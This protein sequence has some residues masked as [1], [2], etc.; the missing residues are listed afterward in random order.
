MLLNMVDMITLFSIALMLERGESPFPRDLRA[1]ITILQHVAD[2]GH[3]GA[4]EKLDHISDTP[5]PSSF[6][7]ASRKDKLE[8]ISKGEFEDIFIEE[9]DGADMVNE[10]LFIKIY[11]HFRIRFKHASL[12]AIKSNCELYANRKLFSD[13]DIKP[14][15]ATHFLRTFYYQQVRRGLLRSIVESDKPVNPFEDA[16]EAARAESELVSKAAFV[17]AMIEMAEV[18]IC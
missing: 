7:Q 10:V 15:L 4:K 8:T 1:A 14:K 3:S 11:H 13:D 2:H 18:H 12:N 17:N 5:L 9:C 16:I 6:N